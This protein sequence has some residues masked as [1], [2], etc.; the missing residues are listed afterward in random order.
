MPRARKPP[1]VAPGQTYGDRQAVEEMVDTQ[2]LPTAGPELH[3]RAVASAAVMPDTPMGGRLSDPTTR[4][5]EPIQAG[6]PMG[7]GPGPEAI[8]QSNHGQRHTQKL[9]Q[10]AAQI[11]GNPKLAEMARRSQQRPVGRRLRGGM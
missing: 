8:R 4:P 5:N 11:T 1:D 3:Q 7:P 2:P 6:L 10:E 9:I